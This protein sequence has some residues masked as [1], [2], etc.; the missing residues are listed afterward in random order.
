M[1]FQDALAR[2]RHR[3]PDG[4]GI[5]RDGNLWLGHARLSILDLSSAGS[6]PMKT[7]DDRFVISYNGEIYNFRELA[8]DQHM[9]DLRSS[10]DTEVVLRMFADQGV[11]SLPR[12][13]G[14]FAFAIYDKL[15]RKLWLV[16][17][18][19]GIKPMYYR[20]DAAG[21]AFASEIKGIVALQGERP[22]CNSPALHE[23]L[24]YGNSLGGRT[25]YHGN[26]A[27]AAGAFSRVG[28][29]FVRASRRRIP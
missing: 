18:R 8:A 4:S 14:M 28:Y 12:F 10:S 6:Q 2:I 7:P 20:I 9:N 26:S 23:W 17:D 24:Y 15:R 13:N 1:I 19:L 11:G 16:R 5:Y 25:L 3:G 29:E 21:F 27:A 22:I